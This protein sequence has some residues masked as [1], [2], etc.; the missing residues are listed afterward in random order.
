MV[1]L[2]LPPFDHKIIEREGKATIF[3]I[4]R[5]KYVALTPEEWV[6]Q[7]FIHY[8]TRHLQYPKALLNVENG[9]KFNRMLKRS[10]IVVY[11]RQGQLFMIVECKAHHHAITP[12]V[13]EQIAVYNHTLKARYVVVTNGLQHYCCRID[14]QQKTY[15]FE[16]SLPFFETAQQS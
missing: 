6:R 1:C 11:D 9:L 3:D 12:A 13:F 10:D 4:I 15:A 14:H 16:E 7:H 8:L 5:K 2:N